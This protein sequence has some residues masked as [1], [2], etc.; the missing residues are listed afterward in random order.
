[1]KRVFAAIDISEELREEVRS[2]I[3]DLRSGFD[4][5]PVKW[6]K[7][8]KLHIT[9]KFAGSVDEEQLKTFREQIERVAKSLT[10]FQLRIARTGAFV[11][12]RGPS[13][14]WLGAEAVIATGDPF[15]TL[16]GL[17]GKR[18]FRPHLTIARI[19]DPGKTKDLIEKHKG[20]D[21]E[22]AQIEVREIV[23]YESTLLPTGSVYTKLSDCPLG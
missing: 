12:R 16:A 13:V 7:P 20:Y 11:E 4:G 6:E 9:V 5:V 15:D 14:L 1:M 3:D 23:I 19:K 8:E 2:Y 10:P 18:P 21:F 22:S 17:S